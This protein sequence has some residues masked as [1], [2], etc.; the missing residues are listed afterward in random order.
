MQFG[1]VFDSR[2]S[3]MTCHSQ[4]ECHGSDWVLLH[5]HFILSDVI[6]TWIY[7][8]SYQHSQSWQ[9]F[10]HLQKQISSQLIFRSIKFKSNETNW[11]GKATV[12]ATAA[13]EDQAKRTRWLLFSHKLAHKNAFQSIYQAQWL[14]HREN[15]C[16]LKMV[17]FPCVCSLGPIWHHLAPSSA[18]IQIVDFHQM[19]S[20]DRQC[21]AINI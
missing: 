3:T 12:A 6:F 16:A 19:S 21:T 15:C 5:C 7:L 14:L 9:P 20:I 13:E 4:N 1:F 2:S 17:H 18:A 8:H 11:K 10:N